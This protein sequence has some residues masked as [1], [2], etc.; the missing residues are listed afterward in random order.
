VLESGGQRTYAR[1]GRSSQFTST[2][3]RSR[4]YSV[5]STFAAPACVFSTGTSRRP[6][7]DRVFL[8]LVSTR[9]LPLKWYVYIVVL[10]LEKKER[11]WRWSCFLPKYHLVWEERGR[12]N[13]CKKGRAIEDVLRAFHFFTLVLEDDESG[14]IHASKSVWHRNRRRAPIHLNQLGRTE[15]PSLKPRVSDR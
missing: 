7:D 9:A 13:H 11:E 12:Y 2:P 6:T 5:I 3:T 1:R 8:L 14:L 15:V 4:F 10:F